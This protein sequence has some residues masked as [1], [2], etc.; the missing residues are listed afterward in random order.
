MLLGAPYRMIQMSYDL[1]RL[2]RK[3]LIRRIP[4]SNTYTLT[5]DEVRIAMFYTKVH[6]RLVAPLCAADQ[7]PRPPSYDM[8]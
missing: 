4:R 6:D 1:A 7:P 8:P 2:S 5:P 3:G